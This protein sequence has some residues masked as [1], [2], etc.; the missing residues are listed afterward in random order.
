MRSVL[1]THSTGMSWRDR[2]K[3]DTIFD[4]PISHQPMPPRYSARLENVTKKGVETSM[5]DAAKHL[6]QKVD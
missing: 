3:I 2:H 1:A 5:S 6:H 4:K